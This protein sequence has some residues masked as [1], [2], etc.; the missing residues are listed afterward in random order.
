MA[1]NLMLKWQLPGREV[2]GK[3]VDS[4]VSRGK[5]AHQ[6][7]VPVWSAVL[8]VVEV[9]HRAHGL[10]VGNSQQ[11]RGD[12]VLGVLDDG[13]AQ[14]AQKPSHA[15]GHII[16]S[17]QLSSASNASTRNCRLSDGNHPQTEQGQLLL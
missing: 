11:R 13:E 7:C 16:E 1:L 17:L 4:A 15:G 5:T 2:K 8:V 6:S 14:H 12:K 9:N 10:Q 3:H